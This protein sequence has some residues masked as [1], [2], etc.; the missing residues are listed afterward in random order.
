MPASFGQKMF[1]E[2]F[3]VSLV[4]QNLKK[5]LGEEEQLEHIGKASL[6]LSVAGEKV[7]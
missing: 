7:H 4:G 1:P 3:V 5:N 2:K 6:H